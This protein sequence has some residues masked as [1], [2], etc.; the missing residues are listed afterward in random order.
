MMTVQDRQN[1]LYAE[2][3][4]ANE[5]NITVRTLRLRGHERMMRMEGGCAAV[6][7]RYPN[8][9]TRATGAGVLASEPWRAG[10]IADLLSFWERAVSMYDEQVS[11][12][13][14]SVVDEVLRHSEPSS[15][16][17]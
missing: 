12:L 17:N 5:I 7:L 10:E 3:I 6:S 8:D 9:M 2:S 16:L 13:N 14:A 1:R 15:K 11:E 4:M